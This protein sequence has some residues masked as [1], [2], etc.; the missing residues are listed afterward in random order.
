MKKKYVALLL[1]ICCYNIYANNYLNSSF[2]FLPT[3]N[4]QA[5]LITFFVDT[6][7]DKEQVNN[8]ISSA[9]LNN[10]N[11][12]TVKTSAFVITGCPSNI[13]VNNDAG[14]CN[15]LISSNLD[16]TS[17][18]GT[19]NWTMTGAT[20][21]S[22]SGQIGSYTFNVGV[23]TINYIDDDGGSGCS[24]T[25]TVN[26]SESPVVSN[27]MTRYP[28]VNSGACSYVAYNNFFPT[29]TDNC[30]TVNVV[31]WSA[32]GATT[33]NNIIEGKNNFV[34]GVTFNAGI[35]TVVVNF[36][37]SSSNTASCSFEIR[38]N[39]NIPP[40]I[41]CPGNQTGNVDASCNFTIPDY[42]G[43]A[44][45]NDNCAGGVVTQ[46]PIAGTVVSVGT[47]NIGLTV[48]DAAGL[49][50]N[51]NFDVVVSDTIPP[52]ASNPAD[53]NVQCLADVPAANPNVV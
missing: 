13:N 32:S 21:G 31:D 34:G 37:D 30:T 35:T 14:N 25:V 28:N 1:L 45:A 38:V 20:S 23:T 26:D 4:L 29:A 52:T 18:T 3:N 36:V 44:T 2:H 11:L 5:K 9:F 19:L 51:C 10:K 48:T 49:T 40:T 15:A 50:A 6:F 7:K 16:V 46:S 8:T 53:I 27:C 22:G 12:K 42:T 41:T 33:T 17:F 43:L 47:T 24:F 39:D